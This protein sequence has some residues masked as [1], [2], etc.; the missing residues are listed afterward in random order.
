MSGI[1]D[2]IKNVSKETALTKLSITLLALMCIW[3]LTKLPYYI[4]FNNDGN[5]VYNSHGIELSINLGHWVK[6]YRSKQMRTPPCNYILVHAALGLTL[7]TMMILTLIKKSW[8]RKYCKP[9]FWFAIIEG[10]HA[11]PASLINDAGF[12]PLFLVACALL[13]G[14]GVTGLYTI[15]KYNNSPQDAEKALF[16]QYV[17]VTVVNFFAA[18]LEMPNILAAFKYKKIHGVFKNYGDE[19]K[20]IFG[21]TFYDKFPEKIGLTIFVGFFL[22]VWFIWPLYLIQIEPANE[23]A[24]D[25]ATE[26]ERKSL[27][28]VIT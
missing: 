11:I 19:P 5:T 24:D 20:E 26:G 16:I 7:V 18:L 21:H 3:N 10:I 2:S 13:I 12:T 28:T 4:S 17:I 27:I 14:C 22:I 25:N 6:G 1:I 8:R 9:F 15:A 23:E